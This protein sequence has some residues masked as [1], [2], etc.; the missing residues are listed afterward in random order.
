MSRCSRSARSW[1]QIV[2][3]TFSRLKAAR[4]SR[5]FRLFRRSRLVVAMLNDSSPIRNDHVHSGD[6]NTGGG[7]RYKFII[8]LDG[9]HQEG[10]LSCIWSTK[11][12][13]AILRIH[14]ANP[15]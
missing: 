6:S 11:P 1:K 13:Q 12:E 7:G 5:S 15:D 4:N 2:V 3:Y 14:P 8:L 9:W 10:E